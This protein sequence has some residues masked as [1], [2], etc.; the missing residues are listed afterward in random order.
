MIPFRIHFWEIGPK[1]LF[2]VLA[3]LALVIFCAGVMIHVKIWVKGTS[4]GGMHFS[5]RGIFRLFV[6]GLLGRRTFKGQLQAGI[7]HALISWGFLGLFLGTVFVSIDYWIIHF[8]EGSLYLW[9]ST[10]LEILGLMTALGLSWALFRRY[11]QRIKRLERRPEDLFLPLWLLIIV[12]SGFL[13]EGARLASQQP[14]FAIWSFLGYWM[15]KLWTRPEGAV[16]SYLVLWWSHALLSLAFIAYMPFSKLFHILAAPASLYMADES[17]QAFLTDEKDDNGETLSP[18][19]FVFL[20]SCTRC[21]RCVEVCPSTG[22]GEDFAPRD[23][24]MWAKESLRLKYHPLKNIEAI[25]KRIERRLRGVNFS[26]EKVWHC[27]T[28]AACLEVCPIYIATP[29]AIQKTRSEIVEEGEDVPS[30]LSQIL[31]RL[32]RY[33]NPLE[34]SRRNRLKWSQDLDVTD[35]AST[36]DKFDLC[37]FVGCTTALDN[38]AQ[39]IARSFTRILKHGGISF[40]TLGV[41]EPCCGD[42]ACR[43]GEK[44]L[45]QEKMETCL[46]LFRDYHI[47]NVITSSPHCLHTFRND[48]TTYQAKVNPGEPFIHFRHYSEF[49]AELI[50]SGSLRFETPF[51]ARVTYHDPCYLGRHNRIFDAPRRILK[52]I[53]GLELVEMIRCRENSLC[54]GGGGGRMW[55]DEFDSEIKMSEIRIKEAAATGASLLVTACPLCLIMLDDGR[56][57]AD[58]EETLTIKDLNEVVAAAMGLTPK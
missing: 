23:F 3:F 4:E 56:K 37:Y 53:P 1:G 21:G 55:Q 13:V 46:E 28:C 36:K 8:L 51:K 29:E 44:G 6:D 11:V 40:G 57:T 42:I 5:W 32:D 35:L 49:L 58:L 30:L 24:I 7:M 16:P 54:C 39:E 43:V 10:C 31:Q 27:T 2:Y 17:P 33:D 20:D 15:S 25:K 9:F 52:A 41:D 12:F 45:F 34:N 14:A 19:E 18:R 38:R 47:D 48:Y 22:A 26:K 50:T